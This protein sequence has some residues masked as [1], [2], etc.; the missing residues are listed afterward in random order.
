[1][2]VGIEA[3]TRLALRDVCRKS[4]RA[5]DQRRHSE[6]L[7]FNAD[8]SE[9]L[10][11]NRWDNVHVDLREEVVGM[12]PADEACIRAGKARAQALR[13]VGIA[14]ARDHELDS[15][16]GSDRSGRPG[17]RFNAFVGAVQPDEADAQGSRVRQHGGR[18]RQL[19][20]RARDDARDRFPEIA[21]VEVGIED[22]L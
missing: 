2:V 19:S 8:A 22:S 4:S 3:E 10:R 6:G 13:V 20:D 14:V 12:H 7:R 21:G 9:R 11:P 15:G 18:L 5:A 17:Q 16:V 1:M